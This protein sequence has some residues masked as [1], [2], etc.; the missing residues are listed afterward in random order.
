[1]TLDDQFDHEW[2]STTRIEMSS[3]IT[4]GHDNT[5]TAEATKDTKIT[6]NGSLEQDPPY[7]RLLIPTTSSGCW[8]IDHRSVPMLD[9]L[10]VAHAKGVEREH[11]VERAWR[12][13]RILAVVL[14][15]DRH[16]IA[17]GH[18]DLERVAGRRLRTFG[19]PTTAPTSATPTRPAGT[20]ATEARFE[21]LVV[22]QLRFASALDERGVVLL[23]GR[24]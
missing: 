5:K 12:G 1:M 15:N 11:L 16:Q 17:F 13:G 2:F 23:I 8:R 19:R 6:K 14:V 3:L 10:A 21:V 22:T 9:Q 20:W 4:K 24:I 7:E 18:H